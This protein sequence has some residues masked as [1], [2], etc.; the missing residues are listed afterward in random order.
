MD[1]LARISARSLAL[2]RL[3]QP[4]YAAGMRVTVVGCSGSYPGPESPA[5]CYLIEH[6]GTAIV[7]DLGNGS[8]GTLARYIDLDALDAVFLTHLHAD[9]CLDMCGFYVY[10]RYHPAGA[11]PQLAVYGPRGT[12][13]RLARAYDM[14]VDPGMTREFAF[15]SYGEAISVGSMQV[16]AARVR[17]PVEAYALRVDAGGRSVVYS[18]DT[19]PTQSLVDVSRG[20]DLALFEASFLDGGE[21]PDV[22][23]TARQAAEQARAAGVGQLVLTH[24]VPWNDRAAT[25]SQAVA[26]FG[27]EVR[28]AH[29]GLAIDLA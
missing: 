9:H 29:S 8:L 23:M 16:T 7:L 6:D 11:R 10:R 28:L 27:G 4:A 24:L 12:A 26:E 14:D 1:L 3:S 22:H 2:T 15:S 5:S 21:Q 20:A 13:D 19:G 17:H 18:G 25:L